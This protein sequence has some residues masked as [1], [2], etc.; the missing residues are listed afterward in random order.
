MEKYLIY[1]DNKS[2]KFWSISTDGNS[3]TVTF[4]R[5]GTAGQ[6]QAKTFDDE[7]SCEREAAKLVAEKMRKGYFEQGAEEAAISAP[8]PAASVAQPPKAAPKFPKYTHPEGMEDGRAF[9]VDTGDMLS[10]GSVLRYLIDNFDDMVE[11]EGYDME[12]GAMVD[13]EFKPLDGDTDWSE[14]LFFRAAIGYPELLPLLESYARKVIV[15]CVE[16]TASGP[17]SSEETLLGQFVIPLLALHDKKY[18]PLFDK[19][20]NSCVEIKCSPGFGGEFEQISQQIAA[21]WEIKAKTPADKTRKL[22]K[23]YLTAFETDVEFVRRE[24]RSFYYNPTS[25][26]RLQSDYYKISRGYEISAGDRIKFFDVLREA[27]CKKGADR[28]RLVRNAYILL[29]NMN[30]RI[31]LRHLTSIAEGMTATG[32]VPTWG[33]IESGD[34]EPWEQLTERTDRDG[35]PRSDSIVEFGGVNLAEKDEVERVVRQLVERFDDYAMYWNYGD[36]CK[37]IYITDLSNRKQ[38]VVHETEL[39]VAAAR[40]Q[41][42][43]SLI[44]NY[45]EKITDYNTHNEP[46]FHCEQMLSPI[47]VSA[48]AAMAW[49]DE[50]NDARLLAY[51]RSIPEGYLSPHYKNERGHIRELWQQMGRRPNLPLSMA[52]YPEL[53]K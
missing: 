39:F 40:F 11:Y 6:S 32:V 51:L 18:V 22:F 4:G 52:A 42:L 30:V 24:Q 44:A 27:L 17:W 34:F 46:L 16:E 19:Y 5:R 29:G 8:A 41:E 10:L 7:A 13:G 2:D 31:P 21:K 47:G 20:V 49:I 9:V 3:F 48:A 15:A 12:F 1:S 38:E 45:V 26:S 50:A 28:G 37:N 53:T 33:A 25:A 36:S 14:E 35:R 23:K 43:K